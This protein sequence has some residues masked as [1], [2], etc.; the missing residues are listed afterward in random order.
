MLDTLAAHVTSVI[1]GDA[2]A[3]CVVSDDTRAT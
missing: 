2:H 3:T 1:G